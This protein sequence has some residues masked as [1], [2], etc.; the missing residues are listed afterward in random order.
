MISVRGS[1]VKMEKSIL[2]SEIFVP[3]LFVGHC[4][5]AIASSQRRF[6]CRP[7]YYWTPVLFET[8][9]ISRL[10]VAAVCSL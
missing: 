6:E 9:H 8:L 10:A 3:A 4:M 1:F 5:H 7:Q 2:F